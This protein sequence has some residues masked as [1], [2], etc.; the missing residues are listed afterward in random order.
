MIAVSNTSKI[1]VSSTLGKENTNS[2]VTADL[3]TLLE[4]LKTANLFKENSGFSFQLVYWRLKDE[5]TYAEI[6]EILRERR[7]F[8][9]NIWKFAFYHKDPIGIKE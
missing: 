5:K 3:K 7:I 2:L 9:E 8:V 1:K 6:I 4:Y